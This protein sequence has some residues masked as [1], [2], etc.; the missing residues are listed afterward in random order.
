LQ[1]IQQEGANGMTYWHFMR[2]RIGAIR[3]LPAK[4]I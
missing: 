2:E 3:E 4:M 1:T